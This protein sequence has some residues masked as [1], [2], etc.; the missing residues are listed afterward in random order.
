MIFF[1]NLKGMVIKKKMRYKMDALEN[2][3]RKISKK[4]PKE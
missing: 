4:L 1:V 2:E 3:A